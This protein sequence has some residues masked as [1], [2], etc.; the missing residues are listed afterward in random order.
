MD[1][2]A[3]VGNSMGGFIG[4]ELAIQFPQRVERLTL[5]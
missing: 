1:A 3:V 4:A 5:V 2:A